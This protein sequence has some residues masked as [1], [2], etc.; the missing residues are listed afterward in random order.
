[1][2]KITQIYG[3]R[4]VIEAIRSEKPID[5]IYIQKGLK[6]TLVRE[7]E[8]ELK[9]QGLGASYVPVEKLNKLT[10]K[11]HQGVVAQIAPVDFQPFETLVEKSLANGGD[12]LFLLLDEISDAR[13][14][15]AILR[16]AECTGVTGV[17]IPGKGAAPVNSDTVKTS[18]GAVFNVPISKVA[19]LKDAVYYLQSSGIQVVAATEKSNKSLYELDFKVPTAIIMGSEDTGI[20]SSLLKITDERAR[21]PMMGSIGS[22]NVS[23]ASGI[24]LYEILRQR[25][26]D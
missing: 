22:L 9:K 26:T 1:M 17:V 18:A 23:V 7:L 10:F 3:I 15:G 2:E 5:K 19:H 12:I 11:N 25:L 13:N 4:A 6:G 20:S 16:T 8:A 21:L 14:F 24:I